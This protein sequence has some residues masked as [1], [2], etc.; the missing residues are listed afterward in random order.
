MSKER[1][2]VLVGRAPLVKA[3]EVGRK[4]GLDLFMRNNFISM[5]G[6]GGGR[7]RTNCGT[8]LYA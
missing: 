5:G 4:N 8:M 3:C 1:E 2:M 7:S 6:I